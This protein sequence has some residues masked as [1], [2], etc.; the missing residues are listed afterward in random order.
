MS[1]KKVLLVL[2]LVLVLCL[3]VGWIVQPAFAQ[4][5]LRT[6]ADKKIGAKQGMDVL[7]NAGGGDKPKASKVQM[8]VGIGSIF[9]MIA[10]L[11]WL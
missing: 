11:K 2:T 8:A 4:D 7:K 6:G 1:A 9:V 10:I 3:C 5:D